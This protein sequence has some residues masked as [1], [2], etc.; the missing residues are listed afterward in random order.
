MNENNIKKERTGR[1]T[2][3]TPELA[4]LILDRISTCKVGLAQLCAMH[5][6]MPCM[7]TI[8]EWRAKNESFSE[9]YLSY[10]KKQ[11]HFL[12]EHTKD[13]AEETQQYLY[14]DPRTGATCIDSGIIA[15]QNMRIKTNTWL[16]SRIN[17]K[18]YGDKQ[19]PE[20]TASAVSVNEIAARVAE[21]NKAGEKDY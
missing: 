3:Y 15:M 2:L 9:Q 11:A 6:D 18:E 20:V 4:Q 14:E 17:P 10:R 7:D 5:D 13:I 1:P 12:A 16:A 21:I 19:Q 8:Y